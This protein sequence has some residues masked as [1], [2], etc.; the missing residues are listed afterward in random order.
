MPVCIAQDGTLM[1]PVHEVL[2]HDKP[3]AI[4]RRAAA[5]TL[6]QPAVHNEAFTPHFSGLDDPLTYPLRVPP[7]PRAFDKCHWY[8]SPPP[9]LVFQ[10][11]LR[12]RTT[13]DRLLGLIRSNPQ[14]RLQSAFNAA[15][16]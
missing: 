11:N 16:D 7:L 15:T 6:P 13:S 4:P 2:P 10:D 5:G 12:L 9:T 8:R 14:R 1:A 3:R